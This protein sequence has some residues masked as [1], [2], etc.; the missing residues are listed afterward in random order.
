MKN[1]YGI[2]LNSFSYLSFDFDSRYCQNGMT[3]HGS[4]F[5]FRL[6]FC[7]LLFDDGLRHIPKTFRQLIVLRESVRPTHRTVAEVAARV[8]LSLQR[9]VY[10]GLGTLQGGLA[11]GFQEQVGDTLG[12]EVTSERGVHNAGVEG[13]HGYVAAAQTLHELPREVDIRHLA[14]AIG[15]HPVVGVGG[16]EARHLVQEGGVRSEMSCG[17]DI[18][19]PRLGLLLEGG[20]KKRSEEEVAQ[21]V[22]G[23]LQLVSIRAQCIGAHHHSGVINKNA[24]IHPIVNEALGK[25]PD[26]GKGG[27]VQSPHLHQGAGS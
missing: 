8:H 10:R 13:K 12:H 15:S 26:R 18:D 24:H 5:T 16:G 1:A 19:D 22:G 14:V 25:G 11:E 17:G 3:K 6:T 21:V 7:Q 23:H 4:G 27:K 20:Q 9:A 2:M